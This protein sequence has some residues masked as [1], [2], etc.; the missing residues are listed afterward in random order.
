MF[1]LN[2]KQQEAVNHI[3]GPLLII[4]GAGSGKT[5]VLVERIANIILSKKAD[6]NGIVA[7]TFTNKAAKELKSRIIQRVGDFGKMT[8]AGTFHSICAGI[9]RKY[10]ERIGYTSNFVIYDSADTYKVV[11][12]TVK[13]MN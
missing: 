6:P 12:N 13:D 8:I 1:K 9:L 4:A 7:V 11:K 3:D 2:S 5:R 10:A